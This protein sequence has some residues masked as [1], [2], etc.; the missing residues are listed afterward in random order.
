MKKIIS[1]F[2]ISA[3]TMTCLTGCIE[4]V[5]TSESGSLTP[6]QAAE[7]PD[8]FQGFVDGLTADMMEPKQNGGAT[9]PNPFDFGYA[10]FSI[11]RDMLGHDMIAHGG[12]DWYRRWYDLNVGDNGMAGMTTRCRYTWGVPY[13]YINNCNNVI[14]MGKTDLENRKVGT[15]IAYAYRALMYMHLATWYCTKPYNMDKQAPTAVLVT[16]ETE[17]DAAISNPR[18]TNE[19]MWAQIMSDL[20]HAEEYLKNEAFNVYLP[21]LSFIYGLKARAY[22]EMEDWPNAEKYAQLAQQGHPMMSEAEYVNKDGGFTTANS[23]WIFA[24]QTKSTY[25]IMQWVE[26][27]VG[28]GSQWCLEMLV[29]PGY[30]S[31]YGGVHTIDRHLFESIPESDFRKQLWVDFKYN[32]NLQ[33]EN[34]NPDDAMKQKQIDSLVRYA[35]NNDR[36][37][38]E[39]IS[40]TG[41]ACATN[42]GGLC[43]KFRCKGGDEGRSNQYIGWLV[44]IPIMRSEEMRLIEIEAVARQDEGRGRQ[45]L[46]EFAKSRDPKFVYGTHNE[47]YGN[48][49]TSALINEIWWQRRVELW[50]EG[51][52]SL[53]LKRLNKG[54]IRSYKNTS[55]IDLRRYNSY[56]ADSE[57][58]IF[59]NWLIYPTYPAETQYNAAFV[60]NPTPVVPEGNSPEYDFSAE[61]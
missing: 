44:D 3:M 32:Y 8:A 49:S 36:R 60:P 4:S 14:A 25:H 5:D 2:A 42:V 27:E 1:V 21:N 22:L 18:A 30:A 13:T 11:I 50:G 26:A 48:R 38:A 16:D 56:T 51:F 35:Y 54:V 10:S 58:R 24:L 57:G 45:M 41:V 46:E 59:P 12:Y 40:N 37:Y 31:T 53:D 52:A 55:H 43:L 29:G 61:R 19:D 15:G 23:S 47:S 33:D 6:A 7:A 17:P 20:D 9:N 39:A 28:W 34:G